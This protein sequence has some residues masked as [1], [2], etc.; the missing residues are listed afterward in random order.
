MV[1]W[2]PMGLSAGLPKMEVTGTIQTTRV[3]PALAWADTAATSRSRQSLST[4]EECVCKLFGYTCV[5]F[6]LEVVSWLFLAIFG[7]AR[8]AYTVVNWM[9]LG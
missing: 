8:A 9:L 6:G 3:R 2:Y 7:A 4:K 5:S 1:P